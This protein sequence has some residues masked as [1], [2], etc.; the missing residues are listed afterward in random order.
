VVF[1]HGVAIPGSWS[2]PDAHSRT[3][4]YDA[5]GTEIAFN[6]GHTWVEILSY[7]DP[8]SY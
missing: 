1:Q 3:R 6:R 4:F 8:L 5:G 7:S 2:K